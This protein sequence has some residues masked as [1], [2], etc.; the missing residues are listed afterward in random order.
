MQIED[1]EIALV[2]I[3]FSMEGYRVV[4]LEEV[5][6][7]VDIVVT[8]SGSKH[9]ITR[10]YLDKLKNGAILCNMGHS[11]TEIDVS[12]LRDSAS[13]DLQ[14]EHV[15][16]NVDHVIWP[17]GKRIVLVAEGRIMNLCCSSVPSFVVS[18]TAATQVQIFNKERNE[19]KLKFYSHFSGF[20]FNRTLQCTTKSIQM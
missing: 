18:I 8:A 5:I 17:N 4:R 19:T 2:F 9:T 13:S 14:V 20:S 3:I 11:N 6:K 16:T 7:Q 15:R 10:D 12:F 1:N